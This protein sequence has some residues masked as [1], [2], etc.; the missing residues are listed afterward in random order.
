MNVREN[1]REGGPQA[2]NPDPRNKRTSHAAREA[3]GC[4]GEA[5]ENEKQRQ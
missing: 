1:Q 2:P 5:T 4:K 3:Q